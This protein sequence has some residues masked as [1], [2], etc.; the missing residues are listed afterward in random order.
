MATDVFNVAGDIYR[1][2]FGTDKQYQREFC[3]RVA[4]E[5]FRGKIGG[6]FV[7]L[8]SI[9]EEIGKGAISI[10]EEIIDLSQHG[11]LPSNGI[12]YAESVAEKARSI[13]NSVEENAYATEGQIQA[14][15]NM[16]EGLQKWFHD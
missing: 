6:K 4:A 9:K 16:L 15:E 10:A 11:D 5:R 12:D 3:K 2:N 13:A 8:K 14:L 7:D 1:D